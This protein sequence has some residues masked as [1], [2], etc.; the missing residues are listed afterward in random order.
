MPNPHGNPESLKSFPRVTDEP[1]SKKPLCVKV[2]QSIDDAVRS[3]PNPS[4][5]LRRV[6]TEAVKKELQHPNE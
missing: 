5:W 2:E 6:I 4:D 1:L 3:L